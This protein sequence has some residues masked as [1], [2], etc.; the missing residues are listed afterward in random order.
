MDNIKLSI[1]PQGDE[2]IIR[3]GEAL[4]LKW[5]DNLR[6]N[7]TIDAPAI[8][9]DGKGGNYD[10]TKGHV[11][12]E[13]D[14]ITLLWGHHEHDGKLTVVG[15]LEHEPDL[16]RFSINSSR[17]FHQKELAN[18][19]KMNRIF[20]LDRDENMSIVSSLEKLRVRVTQEIENGNDFK[21]NKKHLFEQ[22]V[23]HDIK[24]QFTLM[25]P[26]YKG[27]DYRSFIV[28]VNFDITDGSTVFWLESVDLKEL[29]EKE[30]IRILESQIKKLDGLTIIY[31]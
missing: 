20:F 31:K 24:L 14:T 19:L 8:F 5:P 13:K 26:I 18:M 25:L 16:L 10:W 30:R 7:G 1:N 15:K 9:Y 28:D 27:Q 12:V 6:I 21:G 4:P 29:Q 11:E 2:L 3:E 23:Q 17:T 22:N